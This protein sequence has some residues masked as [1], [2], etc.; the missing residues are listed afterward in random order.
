MEE[1]RLG[2]D[3]PVTAVN[4]AWRITCSF[5]KLSRLNDLKDIPYNLPAL[6]KILLREPHLLNVIVAPCKTE[7]TAIHS[8]IE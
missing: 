1:I 4:T 7:V 2:A 6:L 5:W 8:N 3:V